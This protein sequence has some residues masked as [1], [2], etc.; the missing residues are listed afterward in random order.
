MKAIQYRTFG[1]SDVLQLAQT[2]KPTILENEVLIK[3]AAITVNPLEMKI[4]EGYLQQVTPISFPY[5]PGSDVS[6]IVETVGNKV[7]RIKAGDNV[8]ATTYGGTYAEYI[9]LN[10]EQVAI[11]PNNISV[12]EATALAISLTTAYTLLLEAGTL[13][14][15]QEVLIQRQ[16]KHKIWFQ[17]E[18]S[19]AN[20]F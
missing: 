1:H 19:T 20:W 11:I 4:R 16:P 14:E 15:G 5:I 18:G 3:I 7:S 17:K 8:Y 13:Q 6:G 12:N 9:A 2:N 10:E